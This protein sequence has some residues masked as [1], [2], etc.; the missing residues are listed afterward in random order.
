[1]KKIILP[2]LALAFIAATSSCT[3]CVTCKK[4][5]EFFKL[6]DKGDSKDDINN[7]IKYWETLGW[8]CKQSSQMY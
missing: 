5:D 2:L 7:T 8:E 3:K 6:C 1:M 4:G